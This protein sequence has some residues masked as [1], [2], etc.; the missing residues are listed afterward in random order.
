MAMEW[1]YHRPGQYGCVG[2]AENDHIRAAKVPGAS[3]A[4]PSFISLSLSRAAPL[5]SLSL[6]LGAGP[7]HSRDSVRIRGH[8][9]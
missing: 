5:P 1:R 8:L 3:P 4:P 7:M 2:E 6:S 9:A